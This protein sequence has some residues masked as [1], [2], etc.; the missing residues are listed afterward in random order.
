M[1]RPDGWDR[2]GARVAARVRAEARSGPIVIHSFSNAGF[3]TYAATLSHLGPGVLERVAAA[4]IDSAPGFPPHV[5]PDFYARHSAMAVMPMILRALG[6]PPALHHPVLSPATR[7]FMRFWYLLSARARRAMERSLAEVRETGA[8]P[9]LF[10]YS[11]ADRLVEPRWVEA[12]L[13]TL[14][15]RS[16]TAKRWEDSAHVKHMITHRSAYFGAIERFLTRAPS[17]G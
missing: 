4:V 7:A 1:R 9:L 12:F 5:G 13:A 2:E 11:G 15:R 16:V 3:W 8:W 17:I 14:G 10:L 6:R